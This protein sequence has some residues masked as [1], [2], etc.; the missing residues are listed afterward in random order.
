MDKF[1]QKLNIKQ[2][3][4]YPTMALFL[5][6]TL[7]VYITLN[8]YLGVIM[9]KKLGQHADAI[10]NQLYDQI[11][12]AAKANLR[13]A[14]AFAEIPGLADI[15]AISDPGEGRIKLREA[16][17]PIHDRI[18][19]NLGTKQIKVHFT[20]KP[21]TSFLR[22]W[23]QSGDKDEGGDDLSKTRKTV[24]KIEG[25]RQSVTG[26]E[27]GKAG[28]SIRGIVP[29]ISNGE[30]LGSVEENT[31]LI[32]IIEPMFK[33]SDVKFGLFG[34][35]QFM[36]ILDATKVKMVTKPELN[37]YKLVQFTDENLLNLVNLAKLDKGQAQRFSYKV[38]NYYI[39][40]F[41]LNNFDGSVMAV[42]AVALDMKKDFIYQKVKQME[43]VLIVIILLSIVALYIFLSVINKLM[44]KEI[45]KFNDVMSR[46]NTGD[47]KARIEVPQVNCWD[48]RNCNKPDCPEYHD[49]KHICFYNVGSYAPKFGN[50]ILC[51]AILN[52]KF[53]DCAECQ[54]YKVMAG[55][56]LNQLACITNKILDKLREMIAGIINF[57]VEVK[58][59]AGKV[60][61][62]ANQTNQSLTEVADAISNVSFGASQQ[63]EKINQVNDLLSEMREKVNANES[64]VQNNSEAIKN[65]VT[66]MDEITN[67]IENIAKEASILNSS[68]AQ[69]VETSE[70]G[71]GTVENVL[72][73]IDSVY[74][75]VKEIAGDISN[76]GEQSAKI[77]KIITVIDEIA[78]QTNLLALNAA[79]EAAR[80]GEHGK[81]FAV[82]AD[83]VRKL[84]E[85]SIDATKEISVLVK[86]I[87]ENTNKTVSSMQHGTDEVE[88]VVAMSNN[89][90]EALEQINDA[91]T[92]STDQIQNISAST[93]E[94]NA[95]T[96]EVSETTRKIHTFMETNKKDSR[97]IKN[98]SEEIYETIKSVAEVSTNNLSVAEEVT[99]TSEHMTAVSTEIATAADALLNKV[100]QLQKQVN[101]FK[102]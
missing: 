66:L 100:D 92:K 75:T 39:T 37:G 45:E 96:V 47:L 14:S 82:V 91:V 6:I 10:I 3:F 27:I 55:T 43:K 88:K 77:D 98:S 48:I 46:A 84:A 90:K 59:S 19:Q 68:S 42:G 51:P 52:G 56:E 78:D 17:T 9:S 29:I 38:R 15:Y 28:I 71:R 67:A 26:L 72:K 65:S 25:S 11:N 76:L 58:E 57:T 102:V 53:K 13:T 50:V 101:F 64:S 63:N 35:D 99:A 20:R 8:S 36:N 69:M 41:P 32:N 31:E 49:D 74:K 24:V 22:T 23:T 79:I 70:T 40:L 60:A 7:I 87:Q 33:D 83:E 86:A 21:A 2:K 62:N 54:V 18:A 4:T 61:I 80:A 1:F 94:V 34:L 89:A 73:S 93:Q 97:I 16:F 44:T 30:Y 81:G 12:T 85:R 5:V 95:S